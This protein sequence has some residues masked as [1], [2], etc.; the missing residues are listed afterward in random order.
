MAYAIHQM[1]VGHYRH[2]PIVDTDGRVTAV[3]SV[4]DLLRYLTD[5]IAAVELSD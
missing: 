1:D 2:L 4:R 3:I 5:R